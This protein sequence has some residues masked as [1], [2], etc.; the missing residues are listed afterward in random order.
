MA[1]KEFIISVDFRVA[2]SVDHYVEVDEIKAQV[3]KA[4]NYYSD[5]RYNIEKECMERDMASLVKAS[6]NSVVY[7]E[8]REKHKDANKASNEATNI[9]KRIEYVDVSIPDVE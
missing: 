8:M 7:N 2:F 5:G 6:I 4:L 3:S 1:Q 9:V